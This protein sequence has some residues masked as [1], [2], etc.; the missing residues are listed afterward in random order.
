MRWRESGRNLRGFFFERQCARDR[1]RSD[2]EFESAMNTE[3]KIAYLHEKID[4]LTEAQ[5]EALVNTQKL[6]GR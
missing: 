5:Y 2:I 6:L 3:L 4:R 1:I